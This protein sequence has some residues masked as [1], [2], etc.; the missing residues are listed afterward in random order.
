MGTST[1]LRR[2]ANKCLQC[3]LRRDFLFPR[4]RSNFSSTTTSR[5]APLA[6]ATSPQLPLPLDPSLASTRAQEKLLSQQ[7]VTPVGPRRRRAALKSTSSIPFEQL[8]YQCFQEAR[9]ILAE[10]REEKLKMIEEERK[11]IAKIRSIPAVE[12]GGEYS[13]N[14][15]LVRMQ[16]HLEHLKILADIN[17][18]LIKKRYEDGKGKKHSMGFQDL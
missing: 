4:S 2:P 5:E 15:R 18:P 8:P 9:K 10:D 12:L 13:K 16:K 11:R 14:G 6:V 17:D 7:G 3:A 1:H